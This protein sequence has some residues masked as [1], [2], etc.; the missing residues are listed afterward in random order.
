MKILYSIQATGNGHIT[1]AKEI[2]PYLKEYGEVDCMLS[3]DNYQLNTDELPIKYRS[4]GLSFYYND[5]GGIDY[6]KTIKRFNPIRIWKDAKALPVEQYD[7]II[8]DF[9]SIT[10]LAC[11]IKKVGSVA[12]GN[13]Y[14]FLSA[15]TPRSKSG[16]FDTLIGELVLKHIAKATRYVA[17]H[18]KEYDSFIYNP[19]I[20]KSIL[21]A[22]PIEGEHILVYLP[23]YPDKLLIEI[24][25][26][27]YR[28]KFHIFSKTAKVSM[29]YNNVTV[30]SINDSNGIFDTSLI[31]SKGV[32]TAGGFQL[33]SEALYL[34]KRL[35]CIPIDGQYEQL[36]N[37]KAIKEF[38]PRNKSGISDNPIYLYKNGFDYD[39]LAMINLY[40]NAALV[41]L[42]KPIEL[43]YSTKQIVD[44]IVEQG[45]VSRYEKKFIK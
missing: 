12:I 19:I 45:L 5:K 6:W 24:L 38:A 39:C 17:F 36:C 40:F 34:G 16:K 30:F 44:K 33:T 35:M 20:K 1:R 9:D 41:P 21:Q 10:S 8:N 28:Q 37:A 31:N 11:R 42:P 43:K 15:K 32:I 27:L 25:S 2:V 13:Q 29:S 22:T 23:Q 18:Y 3:G 26:K 7:C 4:R 14:S